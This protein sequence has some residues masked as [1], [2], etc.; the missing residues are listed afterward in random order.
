MAK[1]KSGVLMHITSLAGKRG[2]GSFGR[3]AYD[4]VDFL[5]ETKQTYWQILPLTTTSYGDSPYQSFSAIAGNTNLIDLDFLIADGWLKESDLQGIN[6]GDYPEEV[7][8]GLLFR[9]RR[10]LLEKAARTFLANANALANLAAFEAENK[11]WLQDYAEF[12]AIKEHFDQKALQNWDDS[13]AILRDESTLTKLRQ[14][15]AEI[16]DYH[17]VTQFFFFQQ[18]QALKSYANKAGIQIIGDMPIYVSADSVEMWTMP[19]LFKTDSNRKPLYVAGVPADEFSDEGQYWGNPI[20]DWPAHKTSG[21]AWWI[22]RIKESL[23]LYDLIRIDHFKGFSDFW[24]VDASQNTA[25]YGNWQPGPGYDLFRAIKNELGELPIIAENLGYIDEKAEKLLADTAFPGMKILE[26][27]LQGPDENNLDLPHF[28]TSNSIAY[29]GT[30]DNEVVR[31]WY[32]NLSEQARIYT[33]AYTHRSAGEPVTQALLRTLY[34]S[35]SDVVI[36]TMQDILDLPANTRMNTPNTVGNNWKWRMT[37]DQLTRD[38]KEFLKEIT[39]R[40][41]RG[42]TL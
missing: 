8:Y 2:I 29:T 24:Q 19:E 25:R 26:F 40:Y 21:Y 33:D 41:H 20:Y 10:P 22:Y 9:V 34:A 42:R 27:G 3:S 15:L 7:D 23:K 37:T 30:H 38:R 14:N 35:V 32:E 16:I 18:W 11:S 13:K 12:M 6:F 17:K 39:E 31:G 1:R 4:F 36:A 5:V 28:Y